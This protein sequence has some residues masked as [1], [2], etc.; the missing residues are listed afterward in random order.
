MAAAG[1][2]AGNSSGP[3]LVGFVGLAGNFSRSMAGEEGS[4]SA[5]SAAQSGGDAKNGIT[6]LAAR[7]SQHSL[8][9]LRT[10]EKGVSRKG[11]R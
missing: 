2:R 10:D 3:L 9:G 7:Q 4:K 1:R 5:K 8:S 11:E 6:R